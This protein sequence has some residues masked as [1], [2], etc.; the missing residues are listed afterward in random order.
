[1]SNLRRKEKALER[2]SCTLLSE[3]QP[4]RTFKHFLK[5]INK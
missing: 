3:K 5:K 4:Q 2:M 1:M